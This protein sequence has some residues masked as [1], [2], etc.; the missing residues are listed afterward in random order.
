VLKAEP[1]D[2]FDVLQSDVASRNLLPGGFEGAS[3]ACSQSWLGLTI[4]QMPSDDLRPAGVGVALH[5]AWVAVVALVRS[6]DDVE[7]AYRGRIE[8][9]EDPMPRQAYHAAAEGG[10]NLPQA[11]DLIR[12]W[13][14]QATAN[15]REGLRQVAAAAE[16]G[17]GQLQV[18]ALFGQPK[19]LP[20]LERILSAHPLLHAAEGQMSREALVLAAEAEGLR[21]IHVAPDRAADERN[22]LVV[23][24]LG[25][26]AGPPW[27]A[28]Q[29]QAAAAALAVLA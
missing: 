26:A 29:R 28:D 8:L 17:G 18:C 10:L 25:R 14:A 7:L 4:L 24:R 2:S 13:L 23:A 20:P 6:A 3:L 11:E 15:A 5:T 22:A 1:P 21:A 16:A 9:I 12:R 19:P 27:A